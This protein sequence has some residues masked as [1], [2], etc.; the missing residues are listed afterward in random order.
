MLLLQIADAAQQGL[1]SRLGDQLFSII[2]LVGFA[3]YSL[4]KQTKLEEKLEKYMSED[5]ERM[6]DV[7]D[8]NT[9][10]MERLEKHLN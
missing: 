4:K 10:V 5:R 1:I 9:R 8:N 3:I 7:I 6:I 2:M